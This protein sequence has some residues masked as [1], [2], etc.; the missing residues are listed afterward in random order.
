M[1]FFDAIVQ[2]IIQG[3]TEFLPVSSSGHLLISQH[4]LGVQENNLFF[5]IMLHIGTLFAVLAV[6]YKTIWKLIISFF[7]IIGMIFRRE[8]SFKKLNASQNMVV[9]LFVGL[10][11]LFLLFAPVPGSGMNIKDIAEELAASNSLLLVGI[12]LIVT[13]VMLTMGIRKE[14]LYKNSYVKRIG[15]DDDLQRFDGKKHLS[16]FDAIYVGITQFIAAIFPGISRSGSTLSTGL[17]RGV[18][19]QTALDYSFILGVPSILAAAILELKDAFKCGAVQAVG[20][21][22]VLVGMIVSAVVGFLS[23]KL[24]KWLLKTDKMM[25]FVAYTAILG[26]VCV[27][28]GIIESFLGHNIFTG[29]AI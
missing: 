13:A 6:Y 16:L 11:P 25:I 29:M 21:G 24:F 4:I 20:I 7:Q 12:A 3:L 15:S 2:G 27:V 28:I 8:F 23:I 22:P 19:K 5:D 9:A 14:K 10:L 26:S 18:N 17:M 1:T